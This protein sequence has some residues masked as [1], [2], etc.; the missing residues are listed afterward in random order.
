MDEENRNN[1]EQKP[2]RKEFPRRAFILTE[3]TLV[4]AAKSDERGDESQKQPTTVN[5][6]SHLPVDVK[7]DW[8]DT[9]FKWLNILLATVTFIVVVYY[10]QAAFL[11]AQASIKSARAAEQ[12]ATTASNTLTNERYRFRIEERPYVV[13]D[14]FGVI[15]GKEGGQSLHLSFRNSGRTPAMNFHFNFGT[16]SVTVGGD[17]LGTL[18]SEAADKAHAVS[19]SIIAPDKSVIFNF[20]FGFKEPFKTRFENDE[21]MFVAKCQVEYSD[22]FDDQHWTKFCINGK[23]SWGELRWCD[24]HEG[25]NDMDVERPNYIKQ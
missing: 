1:E 6:Q 19:R 2:E 23:K 4:Y 7:R 9:I 21:I 14:E 20:P 15:A 18:T 17:S 8:R 12:A 5:I 11:Q 22:V 13:L 24:R 10:T 16:C 3:N 25:A